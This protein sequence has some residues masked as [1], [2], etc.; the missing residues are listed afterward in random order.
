KAAGEGGHVEAVMGVLQEVESLATQQPAR[1]SLLQQT[2]CMALLC[3]PFPHSP[4]LAPSLA[5]A[6]A[7]SVAPAGVIGLPAAAAAGG[8]V[9]GKGDGGMVV[10]AVLRLLERMLLHAY[11]SECAQVA[12]A[13]RS[14]SQGRLSP[15]RP[16]LSSPVQPVR[17]F[18]RLA[19]RATS[20][21]LT[22]PYF[23]SL[24]SISLVNS[25]PLSSPIPSCPPP[26]IPS[27]AVPVTSPSSLLPSSTSSTPSP[28]IPNPP[29]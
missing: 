11:S 27:H 5:A 2:L 12:L 4:S 10:D 7:G 20:M 8:G 13:S 3:C 14:F 24:L 19:S 21:L 28:S 26:P 23:P 9:E 29:S 18:S 16:F 22:L 17:S 15:S 25:P 6:G 1:L